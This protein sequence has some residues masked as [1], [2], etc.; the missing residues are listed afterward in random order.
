MSRY[1]ESVTVAAP[2]QKV[3]EYVSDFA[4]HADWSAN[5]LRVTPDADG[6][7]AVGS[8]FSTVAKQFGTQREKSTITDMQPGSLFAWDSTGALGTVHHWFSMSEEGG[9]GQT[10]L[11]KGLEVTKPSFLARLFTWRVKRDA[12]RNLRADLEKIKA[13]VES[14]P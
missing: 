9:S 1:E 11:S 8:S 4:K 5:G 6:P 3:Y 2:A 12:P 14:S 10:T 7:A 13:T